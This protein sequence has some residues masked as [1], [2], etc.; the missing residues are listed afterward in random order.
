MQISGSL[1][2]KAVDCYREDL[3]FY[4]SYS[5]QTNNFTFTYDGDFI[6]NSFTRSSL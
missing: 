5:F 6:L 1:K 3:S 4:C 2:R